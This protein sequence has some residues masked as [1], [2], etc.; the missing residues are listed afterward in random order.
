MAS[1]VSLQLES[2]EQLILAA[3]DEL[4]TPDESGVTQVVALTELRLAIETLERRIDL[5]QEPTQRIRDAREMYERLA[6]VSSL[7]Q[8]LSSLLGPRPVPRERRH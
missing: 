6:E 7:R 3:L 2:L 8:G 5:P 4:R 1:D